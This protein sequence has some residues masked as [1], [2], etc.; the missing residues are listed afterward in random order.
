MTSQT[1]FAYGSRTHPPTDL[2]LMGVITLLIAIGLTTVFYDGL[3]Q[4]VGGWNKEEYSYAYL[5]PVISA[6]LIWQKRADLAAIQPRPSWVG[7]GVVLLGLLIGMF[8]KLSTIYT[9]IHYAFI[10]MI[11]GVAWTSVGWRG[12]K[13]IWAPL[14]YLAF[15]VPLPEFLYRNLSAE[16][17]LISSSL[18]VV[19]IRLLNIPVFLEGNVIDLGTYKLQV[20]EACSGLRYL[21]PLMSFGF[22]C[23]YLYNGPHWHKLVLFA[24]TLPITVLINS[25]RIGVTGALVDNFGIASAEGFLHLFEGWI[26]FLAAVGL[27][28]GMMLIMARLAGR[29]GSLGDLLNLDLLWPTQKKRSEPMASSSQHGAW[30][31]IAVAGLLVAASV[32]TNSAPVREDVIPP[33]QSLALFPM[34][35]ND[36]RGQEQVL[37]KQ[38]QD[39]LKLDDHILAD[40]WRPGEQRP[41]N[42]WIAYYASQRTGASAHSPRSCIPGGGWEITDLSDHRLGGVADDG[43]DITVKR[44]VIAKGLSKQLVYYWFQQ[45]GRHMTNEYVV[46]WMIFWDALTRKRT[47]G[48]LV[49]LVT[50]VPEGTDISAADARLAAFLREVHPLTH[51]YIPD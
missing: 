50:T 33:R 34:A 18:G 23:A 16:L 35:V 19:I 5:V 8:G 20:V 37:E 47:D 22:L 44:A 29:G 41:V 43:G 11:I 17:Q 45:R 27:F 6:W 40:Y 2:L 7:V 32:A 30:P 10:V 14:L 36:W 49:R 38:Y 15:M 46:K 21:F 13:I 39:A 51:A 24:S 25:V 48:A 12:V 42:L 26:I 3:R 31:M 9:V 4:M 28:F 1:G